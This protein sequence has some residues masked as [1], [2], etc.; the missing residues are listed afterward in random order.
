MQHW[1]H[2]ARQIT[3]STAEP[4]ATTSTAQPV[5]ANQDFPEAGACETEACILSAGNRVR[6]R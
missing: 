4:V 6:E 3:V 2:H 1:S 5:F